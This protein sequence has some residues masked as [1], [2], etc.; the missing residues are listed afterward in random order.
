[1]STRADKRFWEI[2]GNKKIVLSESEESCENLI[3]LKILEDGRVRIREECDRYSGRI[4][5]TET[6][7]AI[8]E[9]AINWLK[10]KNEPTK[11]S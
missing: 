11:R 9:E 5:T 10:A 4:E 8:F 1:M 3:S 7:I 2:Y 6:A